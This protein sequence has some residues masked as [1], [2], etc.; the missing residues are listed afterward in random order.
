MIKKSFIVLAL[1]CSSLS[2][3]A[4]TEIWVAPGGSDQA[5][6]TKAEP[7][8]SLHSALR[9]ARESRRLSDPS[10]ADGIIIRMQA[11]TYFLDEP[12][13]IRSED[14]GTPESS[15]RIVA[16]KSGEVTL[17]G[18]VKLGKWS[19][20]GSV[21]GLPSAAKGKVWVTD[22]PKVS[23]RYIDFRQLWINGRKAV[24][25]RDT[26]DDNFKRILAWDK[27]TGVL[28][29]PAP[30]VKSFKTLDRLELQLHQMWAIANLRIKAIEYQNEKALVVFHQ[31]ESRIQAE[32]PWPTLTAEGRESPFFLCN[33]IEFL[34]QPGE[35]YL[36]VEDH[37]LY[38]WPRPGEDITRAE[39]VVP[40]LETLID[41]QGSLDRP[42][43]HI[44]FEGI[45]FSYT[46]WLRPSEQ[47]H[48]PLQAGMY[49]LDA[50]NCVLPA[51]RATKTG[52]W[53]I[54]V[55]WVD[56]RLPYNCVGYKI[57]ALCVAVLSTWPH[58][59]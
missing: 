31:P 20:A 3:F 54:R 35:W 34:D 37:K 21:P 10:T 40:Y 13:L 25:A 52:A 22:Q 41:V 44:S 33:A 36:D 11:G 9:Q 38:Y 14:C 45:G 2:I 30:G 47:G 7:K 15:T 5:P 4:R 56:L 43:K 51:Y 16:E 59:G 49:L 17:S 50:Y 42:V 26:N 12:L 46:S 39:S 18:G 55:G 48:V 8:A 19:K 53:K 1:L 29:I 57:R 28:T 27:N 32:H 23:G 24:R 58:V 6:G